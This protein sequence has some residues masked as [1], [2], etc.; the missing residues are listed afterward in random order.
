MPTFSVAARDIFCRYAARN[1]AAVRYDAHASLRC[2]LF[3]T[4]RA[5]VLMLLRMLLFFMLS[6][7]R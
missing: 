4:F 1:S 7:L 2:L 3:A 5:S 6:A